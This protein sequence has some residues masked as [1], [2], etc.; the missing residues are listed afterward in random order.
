MFWNAVSSTLGVRLLMKKLW[1]LSFRL[2]L[3]IISTESQIIVII[4]NS[5]EVKLN[6]ILKLIMLY[7]KI[8]TT[9]IITSKQ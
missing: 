2:L 8:T 6:Y 9:V 7:L 5:V 4:E 3:S 1:A